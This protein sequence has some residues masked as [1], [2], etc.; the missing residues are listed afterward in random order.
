MQRNITTVMLEATFAQ[1][2]T[3]PSRHKEGYRALRASWDL[4][5]PYGDVVN[6]R[7]LIDE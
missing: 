5:E 4:T 2:T 7:E 1:S 6:L 3:Q